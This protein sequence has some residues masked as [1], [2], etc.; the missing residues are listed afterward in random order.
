MGH[1][2][3]A[4]AEQ[5][6]AGSESS[7]KRIVLAVS[8]HADDVEYG[9]GC[10]LGAYYAAG[11]EV[12]IA[13]LA[14]SDDARVAEATR[15][16]QHLGARLEGYL[17]GVDGCLRAST[18]E[19]SW[20]DKLVAQ[21]DT[22]LAPHP[23]DS[24]QDHRVTTHIVNAACRRQAV[25]LAWYRT[26]STGPAFVPNFFHVMNEEEIHRRSTAIS[27]YASQ[28]GRPYLSAPHL[29]AK[30]AWHGWL[31]G[32]QAAEPYQV[33]RQFSDPGRVPMR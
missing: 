20:L 14:A 22:V 29:A 17:N 4:V 19:V 24:H 30:D 27:C 15:A 23:D 6:T 8:P 33:I 9:A 2:L 13:L 11:R 28:S 10:L 12:V 16:A 5:G 1:Y 7:A 21:A 26:P 31:A 18:E 25:C 32:S 3:S